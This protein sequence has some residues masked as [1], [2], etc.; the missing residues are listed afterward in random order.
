MVIATSSVSLLSSVI[1]GWEVNGGRSFPYLPDKDVVMP[2]QTK[3][4]VTLTV[5]DRADLIRITSTGV[6][7][8]SMIMRARVL[9]ALDTSLGK[10]DAREVI[11]VRLGV[12]LET[13]RLVALRFAE[14][15]QDAHATIARG[16]RDL[17]P[18]PSQV[19]GEAEARLIALA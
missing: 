11:T 14:T 18:V 10:V 4:A 15:G 1:S 9:L 13:L 16:Q 2:S 7:S 3:R 17:P 12:S 6:H 19:T 8:A 5:Q